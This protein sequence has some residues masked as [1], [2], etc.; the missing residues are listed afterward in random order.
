MN[1]IIGKTRDL[2]PVT[3][4]ISPSQLNQ[5]NN[6]EYQWYME[7]IINIKSPQNAAMTRGT[8]YHKA[9]EDLWKYNVKVS[10]IDEDVQSNDGEVVDAA[11]VPFNL[12]G[13]PGDVLTGLISPFAKSFRDWG[14]KCFEEAWASNRR[15][16]DH[17]TKEYDALHDSSLIAFLH[18]V[19]KCIM[20]VESRVREKHKSYASAYSDSR[21]FVREKKLYSKSKLENGVIDYV[22][23]EPTGRVIGDWKTGHPYGSG[24]SQEYFRQ[25]SFYAYL[26][27][28]NEGELPAYVEI[29]YVIH[30]LT[31]RYAVTREMVDEIKRQLAHMRQRI[32]EAQ[33]PEGKFIKNTS[34]RW[35]KSCFLG[36]SGLCDRDGKTV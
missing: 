23:N 12:S 14:L 4:T 20:M 18:Y 15:F 10:P 36:I 1:P 28:E 25:L 31:L 21:P 22:R 7:K 29:N 32:A 24:H 2:D 33:A 16:V 35:C 30:G 27:E 3:W 19:D 9:V 26:D 8:A 11:N 6:C 17:E 13:Q 5:F 34:Y